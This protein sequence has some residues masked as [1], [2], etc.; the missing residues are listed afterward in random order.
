MTGQT[1][2][3]LSALTIGLISSLVLFPASSAS[4]YETDGL[5]FYYDFSN[6]SA[7]TAGTILPDL[8]DNNR[9]GTLRGTGL[10][11]D[12]TEGALQFPGGVNGTAYVEL[13]GQ[14]RDFSQG[15]TIEFEGHF[16]STLS[17]WER[18]F[19]FGTPGGEAD[20]FWIGHMYDSGELALETWIGGVNQG[21]CFTST[22]GTALDTSRTFSK[23]VITVDSTNGC[24]IY[25]NGTELNTQVRDANYIQAN[26]TPVRAN[27]SAYP[28]PAVSDRTTNFLGRS[29]WVA[30]R[31]LEGSI[32][33][34]RLYNQPLTPTEVLNNATN[35]SI[36]TV[37]STAPES[38]LAQTGI[39]LGNFWV[40]VTAL[41]AGT[42]TYMFSKKRT[43]KK[44]IPKT[45]E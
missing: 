26:D 19:D 16:G 18:V 29:N 24:R 42:A 45:S 41:A 40:A 39:D 15:V 11:Y 33:Y 8:S 10:V 25:K 5:M 38:T 22:G 9:D 30:D 31:D 37:Q 13:A 12:P 44:L 23:W 17:D 20:D 6:M 35:S 21:R 3:S 27:G 36:P 28:L 34:L 7:T 1:K 2:N 43:P 14:F 32:R 4:A